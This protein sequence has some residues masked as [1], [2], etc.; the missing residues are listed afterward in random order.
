[1]QDGRANAAAGCRMPDVAAPAR[2][3]GDLACPTGR[4]RGIR[5]GQSVPYFGECGPYSNPFG[6][7]AD[8]NLLL[9]SPAT[10]CASSV[11]E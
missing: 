4:S 3:A 2:Q 10:S 6:G 1:M 11:S 8:N 9:V 7:P 5:A